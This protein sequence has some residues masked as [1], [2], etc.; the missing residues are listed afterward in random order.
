MAAAMGQAPVHGS[1]KETEQENYTGGDGR[2]PLGGAE[3]ALL[4]YESN[5]LAG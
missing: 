4:N 3:G 2:R 5:Y 1:G